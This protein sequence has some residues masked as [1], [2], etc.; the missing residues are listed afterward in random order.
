MC[1]D[2]QV[3]VIVDDISLYPPELYETGWRSPPSRRSAI[4]PTR[5]IRA[6]SR[7]LSQQYPGEDRRH[8]GRLPRIADAQPQGEIAECSGD[9]IFLVKH[10]AL[11][12]PPID[13]GILEGITRNTVIELAQKAVVKS[14]NWR[15]EA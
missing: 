12:T 8:P 10:G 5:S 7:Q 3:I 6:S 2:P 1:S 15:D 4:I 9:N 11:R 13:A 14:K